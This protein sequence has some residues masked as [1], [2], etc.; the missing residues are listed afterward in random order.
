MAANVGPDKEHIF[1][2]LEPFELGSLHYVLYETQLKMNLA[3][4]VG[5]LQDVAEGM[6]FLHNLKLHHCFLNSYSVLLSE[7]FRGKIGN[8]EHAQESGSARA[9]INGCEMQTRWM[10]P[11]QLLAEP[12]SNATDVYRFVVLRG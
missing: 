1:L 5:I 12:A 8:L 2:A 7:R 6:I 4:R 9:P 10:A 3:E 11:E